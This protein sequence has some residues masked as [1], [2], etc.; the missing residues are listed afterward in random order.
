ME[1]STETVKELRDRLLDPRLPIARRFRALFSLRNLRGN[2]AREALSAALHD[3]SCL[4]AHEAA[5]AL[6]QMQDSAALPDLVRVLQDEN[7]HPMVR[8]EAAEALGAIG[9]AES[10]GFLEAGLEDSAP[11]VRETCELALRR[12]GQQQG[13]EHSF[14]SVDPACP[15]P[16]TT[17]SAD[18]R[19]VTQRECVAPDRNEI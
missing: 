14:L 8:H 11:E 5:F 19:S 6:G 17:T 9:S 3:P 18:L 10:R 16:D 13:A 7:S 15:A 2:G 1:A 4:L 12:L